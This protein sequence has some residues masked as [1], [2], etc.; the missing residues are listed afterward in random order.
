VSKAL[1]LV[2][3]D[4]VRETAKFVAM[5]DKFFDALNVSNFTSGRRKRKPFQNPY[6]SADDFRVAVSKIRWPM[7]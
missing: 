4:K 5:I 3:G 1:K 2:G 6:R 7:I